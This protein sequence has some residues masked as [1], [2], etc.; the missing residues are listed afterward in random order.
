LKFGKNRIQYETRIWSYYRT[1]VA[2]IYYYPQSKELA[3][4]AS[5]HIKETIVEM[6]QKLGVSMQRK[7][8]IIIYARHSDFL[9][10]NIGLETEDFYNTG[11]ITPI[12][13]DKIFLYF[14]GDINTF[15]SDLRSGIA[16]LFINYF[17]VGETVGS[18]IS[19]SYA[20]AFPIWFTDGASAY[21]SKEWTSDLENQAKDGIKSGRYKK[22][23]YLSAAEQQTAGFSLWR[24]IAEKY[25]ESVVPVILYYSSVSRN[26][27]RA[28]YYTLRL[29]FNE[30]LAEW[31]GYYNE[32]YAEKSGE[33][34]V[35]ASLFRYKKNTHYLHPK[36]SPDGKQLACVSNSEGQ[37]KIWLI[38]LENNKRKCIYR[39]NY[40]IDDYPDYSFPLLAWHP[41]G[42]FLSIMLEYHDKVYFQNYLINKMKFDKRQVVFINKITDFS[43]SSDGRF[44][45]LSGIKNGQSDIYLYNTASRSLEQITNDKADDFAPKFIRKNTQLV[46]SSNR[47]NDT[48]GTE[49]KFQEGKYDLF[50]YDITAKSKVL[51]RITFTPKANEVY[52][53]EAEDNYLSF[54]SDFNGVNNRYVGNFSSV[55]SH[56]DTSIHYTYRF[57]SY[58][59]SNYNTGIYS[60]DINLSNALVAQQIFRKGQWKIGMENNVRFS[61]MKKQELSPATFVSTVG[62]TAAKDTASND[63]EDPNQAEKSYQKRLRQIRLSELKTPSDTNATEDDDNQT[64]LNPKS[65]TETESLLPRNYDVQY[66]INGMVAQADFGYLNTSYQQFIKAPQPLY[67]NPGLSAL[68]MVTI[69]DLMED[70]RMMGGVR[71]SA[72]LN[73]IEF[74]YSYEYLKE[75]LDRQLILHY[76]SLKSFDGRYDIRQQNINLYYIL[77][78]PFDRVNSL[79]TTFALRYN[80]YDT[81]SIDLY[82]L[83]K[84][85][86][87][88]FW[89]GAKA[90]YIIDNTREM[91]I[92]LRRGFRGKLFAEY[93]CTPDKNFNNM[94]VFG[95][96]MRHY[97]RLHRTLIWAN[98]FAAST[99]AGKNRLI[100]YMGGVD[101]W[102]FPQFNQGINIDTSVNYTFQTLATNMRGFSQNIRNGTN[103]FVINSE[104]RFQ[105]VQCLS[106]K[107]LRS[108]F[109]QSIQLVLFG[110]VGTAWVGLHPYLENNAL[111]INTIRSG[112]ITVTIK[113]QTEPIV[114]GF[115]GG[116][117]FQLF[118]YF[119]RIDYARGIE[120][121]KIKDK[122]VWYLSFNLDF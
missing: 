9:Q 81:R 93:F 49:N 98:R 16:G 72:T 121:Y 87:H 22:I 37:V 47:K 18:N 73:N 45:A 101:N 105:I 94:M 114:G 24:Y 82:S 91:A 10:S 48:I 68:L 107:P 17:M 78:Y 21:L 42:N 56:I 75:R 53:M 62:K 102:I 3:I 122:G 111:F 25:G 4:L 65:E 31:I 41:S 2:D 30:L 110:D 117:R 96:D 13:G 71:M 80:R 59:V 36:I 11:G 60:Q 95:L 67:L 89:L 120:N 104:F 29:S 19:A 34:S 108:E 43:Y 86:D 77:K 103:F 44:I 6:E 39:S 79:H 113:K 33:E 85:P 7:M 61:D 5:E 27:E 90:E 28:I 112:D 99:S 35:D 76:Q 52:A 32:R 70:Y 92:N 12:Y 119:I 88:K 63:V 97:A 69:R 26:Y 118:G 64:A 51:E 57:N 15:L 74:L 116:I 14:K 40:R 109:L 1:P 115:G 100:Y 38:N 66:F 83:K 20:S 46:F 8:Q 55:I 23:H 84:E 106:K 58:P 54:I 50:L